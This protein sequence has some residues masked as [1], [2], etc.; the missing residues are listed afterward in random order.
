[1]ARE[2]EM[3]VCCQL[4]IGEYEHGIAVERRFDFHLI[5]MRQGP[6]EVDIANLGSKSFGNGIDD[7]MA[8]ATRA[9]ARNSNPDWAF[10]AKL[11]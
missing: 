10:R 4:L 11:A 6:G 5:F 7:H 3:L 9:W 8:L 2:I 1:V